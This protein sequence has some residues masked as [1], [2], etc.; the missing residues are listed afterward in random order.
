[1]LAIMDTKFWRIL[2]T[3]QKIIMIVTSIGIL[4]LVLIQVLLRYVFVKPLMGVEELATMVG[5]WLYFMGA[6]WGTADRSHIKADLMQAAIK[7]P[8]KLIWVKV[9][10]SAACVILTAMM[11]YWGWGYTVWGYTKRQLSPTLMIPMIYSQVSIFVGAILMFFY[12]CV[13]LADHFLQA[14]GKVPL[15]TPGDDTCRPVDAPAICPADR[16]GD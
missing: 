9:V 10:I 15:D 7:D 4:A 14:V 16:G 5:F 12:F 13:E 2:G 1:M 3:L 8:R 6:S 11:I